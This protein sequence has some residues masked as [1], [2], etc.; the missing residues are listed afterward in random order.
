MASLDAKAAESFDDED[1]PLIEALLAMRT[2]LANVQSA[3]DKQAVVAAKQIAE[4]DKQRDAAIQEAV[5]AKAKLAAY[6]GGSVSSTPQQDADRDLPVDRS[7]E[8]AK[9][10]AAALH[11]QKDL[12]TQVDDLK[13]ELASERN[14]RQLADDTTT[15][16]QKR[17][18]DL[19]SYKQQTSTEFEQLKAELHLVRRDAR[20]QSVTCA[21]AVAALGLIKV[22]RDEFETKYNEAAGLSK[23]HGE[24]F[25]SLRS[26]MLASQDASSHLERKLDEE[27][28]V[29]EIVEDKLNKLKAEHEAR[30]I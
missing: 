4:A 19:E 29:R 9:K 30:H 7:G 20:E 14:A 11:L 27:R 3:V 8:I 26:A 22:E 17:M 13:A 21:E 24:T 10:L 28:E 12:R 5:Y 6:A 16:A 18:A 23:Q 1:R 2:E 15:A 25:E